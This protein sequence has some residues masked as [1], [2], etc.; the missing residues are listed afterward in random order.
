M[1]FL[2]RALTALNAAHSEAVIAEKRGQYRVWKP[3]TRPWRSKWSKELS[4]YIWDRDEGHCVYCGAAG[5]QIDHIVPVSKGGPSVRG[6]AVLACRA[7]NMRKFDRFPMEMLIR[8][9]VQVLTKG[10]DITWLEQL[11]RESA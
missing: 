9:F 5:Q 11:W 8:A 1:D 7:C 4:D 10:E 2:S 3:T 6:N